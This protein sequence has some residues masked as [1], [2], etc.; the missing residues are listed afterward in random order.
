VKTFSIY[1][2]G[3]AIAFASMAVLVRQVP[4]HAQEP[5]QVPPPPVLDEPATTAGGLETA[6]VSGGCF[7]GVQGVFEHV[8]GVTRVVSGYAGGNAATAHYETVSEGDTG[9]A[10][11]VQITYDPRQISYGQLLQIFF[12]VA[13][14]PTQLN[15]QGPDHGSQYRS[16]IF[17]ENATQQQVADRYIAQLNKTG[18]FHHP[19]VT[20]TDA[21][22]GFYPAEDYHQDFLVLNPT[23]AYIAINDLPKVRNLQR[24]FPQ[25][26]REKPVLVDSTSNPLSVV[27]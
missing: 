20:R 8:K 27:R 18:V 3:A 13:H 9:H 12:S 2:A 14:D 7:W 16:A 5:L 1:A 24:L 4:A 22:Q 15:R 17:P 26:Y 10:E 23:N 21:L 11:S 6:V 25:R 19:I